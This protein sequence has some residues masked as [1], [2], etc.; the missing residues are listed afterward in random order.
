MA[1][2]FLLPLALALG[3]AV[4]QTP[5]ADKTSEPDPD[6]KAYTDA[7]KIADAEQ[8]VAAME[9]VRKDFPKSRYAAQAEDAI[10]STLVK[11]LPGEQK[12]I[13]KAAKLVLDRAAAD[14]KLS[15]VKYG[16]EW[17]E[18]RIGKLK[19][20]ASQ[21]LDAGILLPDA[22]K[23][24]RKALAM[25]NEKKW[26]VEETAGYNRRKEKLPPAE[27]L[28]K[29]FLSER[30]APTGLLGRILVKEGRTAEGVKLLEDAYSADGTDA[31][32]GSALGESAAMAGDNARAMEY[33]LQARLSGRIGEAT[34]KVF[35]DLYR[36]SHNGSLDGLEATIDSEYR[37]RNPDPVHL[38]P[39]QATAKRTDRL[40][41]AEMFTGAGCPPCAGADV[42]FE[43][44]MGRF[45]RKDLAVVMYHVHVPRPDPMTLSGNTSRYKSYAANGVPTYL[46]DGKMDVGGDSRDKAGEVYATFGKEIEKELDAPA[47]AA[48]TIDAGI[49]GGTVKVSAAVDAIKSGSKDL[50]VEVL[51]VEKE[52]RYLGENG[53]LFHPMVVRAF[54]GEKGEG[55][56][57]AA[58]AA[59][60]FEAGF[61]LEAIG[62]QIR[63]E[64][65]EYEAA[66]HRGE[67]FKFKAKKDRIDA[68]HLAVVVFV[69]DAKS[70]HVLQAAYTDLGSTGNHE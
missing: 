54:G 66:G 61:D 51:L 69:H 41:L 34:N 11:K 45:S 63:K 31:N 62:K 5:P 35:E 58:N 8:K 37:K 44:A 28:H 30:A 67:P 15:G 57:V 25:L 59:G 68:G 39:Y 13:G 60:K 50:R 32:V 14:D 49:E 65:D 55:Y 21:F 20:V 22:E 26:V 52:V 12:R 33:L 43:A 48:I 24:A 16:V 9:K 17:R 53:I 47:E 27:Q 1:A 40:V 19:R 6:Q 42:A 29:D 70:K 3:C 4:A 46:I 7:N 2:R 56:P 18:N 38:K 10:F 64:L 36:K 23:H